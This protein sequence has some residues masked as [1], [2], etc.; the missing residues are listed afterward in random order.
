MIP[1]RTGLTRIRLAA[2]RLGHCLGAY[3]MTSTT[4]AS[5]ECTLPGCN[6]GLSVDLTEYPAAEG[7]AVTHTCPA[8]RP[9]AP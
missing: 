6:M 4:R 1:D 7:A 2:E 5:A 3:A 9:V 8:A